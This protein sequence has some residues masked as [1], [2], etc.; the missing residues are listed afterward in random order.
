MGKEIVEDWKMSGKIKKNASAE[1]ELAAAEKLK[2]TLA[3]TKKAAGKFR[4]SLQLGK[5]GKKAGE[6]D[7]KRLWK[8]AKDAA[9]RE[10]NK[11]TKRYIVRRCVM[12]LQRIY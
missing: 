5:F 4:K 2:K 9:K 1:E 11:N 8:K 6:E 12:R 10:Y 7:A 3:L